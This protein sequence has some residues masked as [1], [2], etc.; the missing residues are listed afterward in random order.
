MAVGGGDTETANIYDQRMRTMVVL[1]LVLALD[2][3]AIAERLKTPQ[4]KIVFVPDDQVTQ[5]LA[6][7]YTRVSDTDAAE[8]MTKRE[9][10][11]TEWQAPTATGGGVVLVVALAWI[12]IRRKKQ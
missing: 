2:G 1:G 5:A 7:G 8:T 9:D 10:A 4:G 6:N 12:A 3:H 11:P